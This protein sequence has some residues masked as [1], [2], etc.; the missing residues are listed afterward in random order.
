MDLANADR[1][2]QTELFKAQARV[3]SLLSDTAAKNAAEQFNAK[4]QNETDQ[5]MASLASS[6]EQFNATQKNAM[7][8][9]NISEANDIL[10]VRAQLQAERLAFNAS[11]QLVIAQSNAEWRRQVA[12]T[13]TAAVNEAN[14]LDAQNAT[15]MTLAEFNA[16]AQARRDTMSYLFTAT[17]SDKDRATEIL[18]AQMAANSAK[19]SGMWEAAGGLLGSIAAD[20]DWGKFFD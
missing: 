18:M 14:L 12:T 13:N 7:E 4:S 5:F 9:A 8:Q 6:V 11:N 20:T 1:A 3:D 17:E 16:E 2:Q 15:T 10:K 19:K